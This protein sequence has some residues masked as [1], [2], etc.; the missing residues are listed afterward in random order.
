M[1]T[2]Y[3][4]LEITFLTTQEN[5][6]FSEIV[7]FYVGEDNLHLNGKHGERYWIPLNTIDFI[8]TKIRFEKEENA[9]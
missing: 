9:E 5:L 6:T 8:E 1:K 3:Y 4:D 2:I 7:Y